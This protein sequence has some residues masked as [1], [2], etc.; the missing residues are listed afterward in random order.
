MVATGCKRGRPP[1]DH[2]LILD[3]VFW[4]A[5]TGA[6]WRD[7]RDHFGKWPTVY[8]QFRRW[9]P[10]GAWEVLLD[11]LNESGAVPDSVRM[12][13]STIVRATIRRL[14][15]KGDSE[16]GSR[17]LKKGFTTKIH[18]RT[19]AEGLPVNAEIT[20]GEVSDFKGHDLV[21]DPQ[22]P[23][24]KVLLADRGYDGD[25]IRG[26]VDARGGTPV[27]PRRKKRKT[28]S[29]ADSSIYAL[30]NRIERCFNRLRNSRRLA[31]RDDKTADSNLGLIHL[32]APRLWIIHFASRA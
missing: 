12:I 14:A 11:A 30:R 2:R 29:P 19:N 16:T 7:L 3:G 27:I 18:L 32:T 10:A 13:G 4:I 23:A 5:R 26:D 6:Q 8:R 1:R 28:D 24:P 15:H 9:T 25:R 31:T 21:M 22:C 20:G 17:A